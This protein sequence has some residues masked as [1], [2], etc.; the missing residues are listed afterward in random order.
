MSLRSALAT[1]IVVGAF[2]GG[3]NCAASGA[4][5][6]LEGMDAFLNIDD[7][8]LL[9]TAVQTHQFCTYDRAGD[10]YDHEYFA[11]YTEADG[12]VVL[13]DAMGPGCLYRHHMNIWRDWP[14]PGVGIDTKGVQIRYYFDDEEQPRI[15]MDVSTF[16]SEKNPLGIFHY[17]LAVDGGKDFRVMYCPMFFKKRLKITLNRE[18]G[19]P[20]SGQVPWT[21]R[22]DK[23][24]Q[25]RNHWYNFTYHTFTE[26]RD[27]QSWTPGQDESALLSLWDK[28]KLGQD[29]KPAGGEWERKSSLSLP[30]GGRVS[31]A[32]VDGAGAITSLRMNIEPV[33]EET[34]FQTWLK[35]SWD[36]ASPAQI[37]APL[38]AFFGA[39]RTALEA[40]F[41]SLLV[42]Y[43]PAL[44]Y[45]YFPMP[46][47]K[48]A[49]IELENRGNKDIKLVKASVQ[50]RPA[51][52]HPYPE[53][54]SGYFFAYYHKEFPRKEGIDYRYLEWSGAGH[55][56]GHITSR[57][58][59][60]MEEDERTYFDDSLTP[61]IYGEGFE[62]DHG[63]GWGLKNMQ[64][65]IFGAIATAGGD[66]TAY[67]FFL[68]DLYVFQ[69]AIHHGHQTYGPHSPLG[70]E[71]MYQVGKEESVT[72]FYAR[73]SPSLTLSDE[74]DVGNRASESSHAYQVVGTRQDKKGKFWYDGEFNNVLFKTPPIEDDGVAFNGYSQ[75]TVKV[76]PAN[77]GVRIR[78]RTDKDNNRQRANVYV[79][80]VLVS[81][82]PWYTVDYEKTY[83]DIRWLDADFEIPARYTAGKAAINL[84]IEYVSGKNLE[85]DE[86]YYWVYSYR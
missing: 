4:Q 77:R 81:E 74:L 86:Y 72:F 82:R 7:L 40:S 6:S 49:K 66:G 84:K 30:A 31:L 5:I 83:R 2:F 10:N 52:A 55:V 24:P 21:G 79:D 8:P 73:E 64:Q 50:Y 69:S 68:P 36:G 34:L 48:S 26:D 57:F 13:F 1:M 78:R 23:L 18:P 15:D 29:P 53:E 70:H 19:G 9:R 47:W 25:R 3:A 61:Q 43:S 11:L 41:A 56:L 58:D 44:M 85:W 65:A 39:H 12:E 80:G 20:G 32:D 67:R 27:I 59:T 16:F 62:D 76:D 35:I 28:N 51:G 14:S 45:S 75:F 54:E 46:F 60:S 37:E 38:G 42:G 63:M 17:P 71:G 22:Y 33:N